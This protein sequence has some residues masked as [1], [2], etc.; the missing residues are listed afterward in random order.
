MTQKYKNYVLSF[1]LV[2]K[3]LLFVPKLC[4]NLF[5]CRT[6]KPGHGGETSGTR[7]TRTIKVVP[8]KVCSNEIENSTYWV[9][10]KLPQIYTE[11]HAT[12]PIRIYAKLQYRFAV[13]SGSPSIHIY[14][15]CK[16]IR[17]A[18]CPIAGG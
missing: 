10:Q 5:V 12:F 16:T 6:A 9:T 17:F 3:D 18:S 15:I 2:R 11:N 13:T 8:P 14:S 4:T 1:I 7:L